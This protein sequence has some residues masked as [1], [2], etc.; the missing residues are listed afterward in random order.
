MT[1]DFIRER[2]YLKGVSPNT[3]L[4]YRDSFNAF[5][6][7]TDSKT[8]IV[9]RIEELMRRGVKAVSINTYLRRVNA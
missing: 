9:Q 7:A 8:A 1:E 4:W 2:T 3:L 5:H 6:G